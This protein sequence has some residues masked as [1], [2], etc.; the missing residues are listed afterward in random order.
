MI[1]GLRVALALG[2]AASLASAAC[3]ETE[4]TV[5]TAETAETTVT[6]ESTVSVED[7]ATVENAPSLE[8]YLRPPDPGFPYQWNLENTGQRVRENEEQRDAHAVPPD[9]ARNMPLR[10]GLSPIG[11]TPPRG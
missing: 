9:V 1:R 5:E 8:R 4:A 10:T 3:A 6:V 11:A 7:T 2:L